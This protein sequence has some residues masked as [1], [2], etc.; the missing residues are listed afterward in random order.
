MLTNMNQ[1]IKHILIAGLY[2]NV[3]NTAV[4]YFDRIPAIEIVFFR[5]FVS[6]VITYFLLRRE[7]YIKIFNEHTPYLLLRGLCGAIA[8]S[9][10]FTTIQNMPLASA[11]TILYLAPIFTV[12]FASFMVKEAP[13]F[14]QIP[15]ML[16]SFL[17][18]ALLKEGTT[19]VDL[20]YF[21]MGLLA[22]IFAGL[23]YNFIRLLK[24]KVSHL[25]VIFYFPL[26]TVPLVTPLVYDQWVT[27]NLIEFFGLL[28]IGTLTQLAQVELTKAYM[29]EKASK[30]SHFNY[31]T[32]IYAI[33]TAYFLFNELITGISFLGILLI[34]LGVYL[35]SKFSK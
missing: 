28:A 19:N 2:F 26:V 25:L 21:L 11:V 1:G 29:F 15:A 22:A 27:P 16:I 33:I 13:S 18:A 7:S 31:L 6:L 30:I 5:S 17:G 9:L 3:I 32:S 14:W 23:A 24:G 10:Y 4:K 12:I 35:S 34:V 8:L 20:K